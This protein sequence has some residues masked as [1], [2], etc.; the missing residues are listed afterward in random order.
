ME[1]EDSKIVAPLGQLVLASPSSQKPIALLSACLGSE[2]NPQ[3]RELL[4][5]L[6]MWT[7]FSELSTR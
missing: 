3:D 5:I 2:M 4:A 1:C 7:H 6:T